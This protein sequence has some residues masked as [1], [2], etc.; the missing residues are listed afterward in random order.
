VLIVTILRVD[1]ASLTWHVALGPL[2]ATFALSK[3]AA[4]ALIRFA[5]S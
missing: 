3:P 1:Q 5:T 4:E 2:A